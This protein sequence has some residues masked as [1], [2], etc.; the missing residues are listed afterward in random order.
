MKANSWNTYRTRFLVQAKQLTSGFTFID[1]LGRQ[2]T[3]AKGD[4]IVE[5]SQGVLSIASRQIFEDIY[6]PLP[7]DQNPSR[8]S[9][10]TFAAATRPRDRDTFPTLEIAKGT[11]SGLRLPRSSEAR[12]GL[13][14]A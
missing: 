12:R 8:E 4:Y 9:F 14:Y 11:A 1:A 10:S 13:P 5:F 6:V 2:H 7:A 3:G